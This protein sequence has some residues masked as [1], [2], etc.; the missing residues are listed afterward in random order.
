MLQRD[1][2]VRALRRLADSRSTRVIRRT[3]DSACQT[4]LA[5]LAILAVISEASRTTETATVQKLSEALGK[6][7][8]DSLWFVSST[9]HFEIPGQWRF[10]KVLLLGLSVQS[11]PAWFTGECRE[12]PSAQ[13][14]LNSP[15]KKKELWGEILAWLR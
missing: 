1:H 14:L 10:S 9:G 4:N 11:K 7:N 12:G 6:Q 5:T 2:S 13:E 8:I 3:D 15:Q